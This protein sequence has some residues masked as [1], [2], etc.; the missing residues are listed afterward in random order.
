MGVYEGRGTLARALKQLEV[1]WQEAT[2]DWDDIRAHEFERKHLAPLR[3]DLMS[4]VSA[5]DHMAVLLNKIER[6]CE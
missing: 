3:G 5:M 4:A 2:V 6:E 1:S